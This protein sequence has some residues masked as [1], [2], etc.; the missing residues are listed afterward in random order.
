M[1]IVILGGL[2]NYG[3]T[4]AGLAT[5]HGHDVLLLQFPG[6]IRRIPGAPQKNYEP[7]IREFEARGGTYKIK[8]NLQ[9]SEETYVCQ[10][11]VLRSVQEIPDD[12]KVLVIAYPSLLHESIGGMLKGC[13]DGKIVITFTDRFLGGFSVL[14]NAEALDT[15][16][17][18]S[19]SATPVTA[20]QDTHDPFKRVVFSDKRNIGTGYYPSCNV[21]ELERVLRTIVPG[22]YKTSRNLFEVAF[23][24]TP[25]NLHA[26]HDLLNVVRYEQAHEFTMFHEGFTQGVENIINAIS[27]ER[28]EIAKEFNVNAISFL[29]YER[30]TYGYE[31]DSITENRRLNP[32]LNQVPAPTSLYSC[33]GIE[34]VACAL[35]PLSE[36]AR[37][38]NVQAPVIN[39]IIDLWSCYLS[40]DLRKLG[41]TLGSLG[42][43]DKSP[44]EILRVMV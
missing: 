43:A 12:V 1:R 38:A 41:R 6:T 3:L 19:V 8:N 9:G 42:L 32:Q 27:R 20:F 4:L 10:H 23:N 40:Q 35:V 36:L 34:D 18:V 5:Q 11:R 37:L 21:V 28:C 33:K 22:D 25:S 16:R 29:E 30:Q 13:I 15:A 14:K 26:P 7:L 17:L 44:E 24:C 39:S 31:G 2:G